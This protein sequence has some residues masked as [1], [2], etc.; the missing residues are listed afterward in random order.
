MSMECFW[1]A[2]INSWCI[3]RLQFFYYGNL[4]VDE[5]SAQKGVIFSLVEPVLSFYNQ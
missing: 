1:V 2:C 4:F 5:Y 3:I